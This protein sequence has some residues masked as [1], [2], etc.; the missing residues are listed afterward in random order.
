MLFAVVGLWIAVAN[1]FSQVAPGSQPADKPPHIVL[2]IADDLGWGDVGYHGSEIR[3]PTIDRLAATGVAF[4]RFYVFPVCTPTRAALMTGRSPM[5][6]GFVYGALRPWLKQGLPS[7][8]KLLPQYLKECGYATALVGKWHLGH[9]HLKMMPHSRGF[10]HFYGHLNGAIEY[11]THRRGGLDWQRNGKSVQEEGYS[12][13]LLG[14]E[15]VRLITDHPPEKPLFLCVSFNA[16][17]TPLEAPEE[18]VSAYQDSIKGPARRTYAAMVTSMDTAM[19]GILTALEEKQMRQ[20]TLVMFF[21]DNGGNR[22]QGARN[23]PLR[24]GKFTTWEGGIRVPAVVHWPGV[25]EGGQSSE[26]IWSVLDLL[27]T[28]MQ[29]ANSSDWKPALPLDGINV[30]PALRGQEP[31]PE[32][33]LFFAVMEDIRKWTVLIRGPWKLQQRI[34]KRDG[35]VTT[36]LFDLR[37][38]PKEQKNI[39]AQHPEMVQEMMAALEAWR[40]L[41]PSGGPLYSSDEIPADWQP[42]EDWAAAVIKD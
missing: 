8:E 9:T 42:P 15:A 20:N 13:D 2:F 14:Q 41:H 23:L 37:S 36:Q 33:D 39:A 34:R 24:G 31:M 16:P 19:N 11:F 4:E 28:L 18:A 40:A 30:L 5:R 26:Q 27:P 10:D 7:E 3:T 32:R 17:H 35:N 6:N 29:V 12:T 25:L 22:D 21:S 38:D 1:L